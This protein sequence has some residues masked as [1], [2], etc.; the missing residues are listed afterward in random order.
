MSKKIVTFARAVLAGLY[1]GIAG[2]LYMVIDNH[3]LGSFLFGFALLIIVCNHLSLFTGKVGYLVTKGPKYIFKVLII[4]GGNFIGIGLIALVLQFVDISNIGDNL[5]QNII[6][7]AKIITAYKLDQHWYSILILSGL[8]GILMYTAVDGYNKIKNEI[9][10]VLVVFFAVSIFILA[11]F[12]HSIADAFY[13][14][15]SGTFTWKAWG[16]VLLMLIGNGAGACLV[17]FL[18]KVIKD[19]EPKDLYPHH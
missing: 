10:K 8:C 13:F 19:H 9:A 16:Y 17:C 11:K 2:T 3:I 14:L 7:Q 12:E 6:G 1:V 15:V 4:I 18:E 5:S